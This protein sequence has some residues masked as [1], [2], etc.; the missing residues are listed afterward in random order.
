VVES[1]LADVAP[2]GALSQYLAAC[3]LAYRHDRT[4]FVHGAVT[5]ESLGSVPGRS[6]PHHRRGRVDRGA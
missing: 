6:A 3:Q 5:D 1:F 4:L 2:E